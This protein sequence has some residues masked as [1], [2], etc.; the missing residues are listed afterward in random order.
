[1]L[2]RPENN[3]LTWAFIRFD[4]AC[5]MP[6]LNV[7]EFLD[8]RRSSIPTPDVDHIRLTEEYRRRESVVWGREALA[9]IRRYI[10]CLC[11]SVFARSGHAALGPSGPEL[12]MLEETS[13]NR[14]NILLHSQRILFDRTFYYQVFARE[15]CF[16][17]PPVGTDENWSDVLQLQSTVSRRGL[18]LLSSLL[19]HDKKPLELNMWWKVFAPAHCDTLLYDVSWSH[20]SSGGPGLIQRLVSRVTPKNNLML[21][22]DDIPR[23]LD[24]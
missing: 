17:Q 13:P 16:Q 1:L 8:H 24:A 2:S 7:G 18:E 12:P 6:S 19:A 5:R 21:G 23:I 9:G 20:P 10:G 14:V 22:N 4:L 15:D 11:D 3:R